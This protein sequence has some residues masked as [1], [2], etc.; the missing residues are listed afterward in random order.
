MKKITKI[1]PEFYK[2]Y[3]QTF[4]QDKNFIP[5]HLLPLIPRNTEHSSNKSLFK[6]KLIL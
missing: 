6:R 3:L 4:P 2:S 1:L 5:S